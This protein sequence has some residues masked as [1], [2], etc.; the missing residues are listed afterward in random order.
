[1]RRGILGWGRPNFKR[2]LLGHFWRW[3]IRR[4]PPACL[5]VDQISGWEMYASGFT[6]SGQSPND[7]DT[8][9]NSAPDLAI[10]LDF[11]LLDYGMFCFGFF[12]RRINRRTDGP[13]KFTERS[14]DGK[15]GSKITWTDWPRNDYN[16]VRFEI[17]MT[18]GC[19]GSWRMMDR[20]NS[21]T[22]PLLGVMWLKHNELINRWLL[23]WRV[24]WPSVHHVC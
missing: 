18:H 24:E 5:T 19:Q 13:V 21:L 22:R 3:N 12:F 1:M 8:L 11:H 14:D 7:A 20:Q 16:L 4:R 15:R 9:I 17:M 10:T 2:K 6:F 23:F